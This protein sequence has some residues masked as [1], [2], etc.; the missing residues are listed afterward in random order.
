M[1]AK[2]GVAVVG[3]GPWGVAL[4]AAAARTGKTALL[5]SRR[6]FGPGDGQALPRGVTRAKDYAE[7]AERTRL[8]ILRPRRARPRR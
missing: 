7:I 6:S 3:G 5:L 2:D 8:V 4:A 1:S